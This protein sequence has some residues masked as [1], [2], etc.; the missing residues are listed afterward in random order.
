MCN[1]FYPSPPSLATYVAAAA[2]VVVVVIEIDLMSF[3]PQGDLTLSPA[4]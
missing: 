1:V 3:V 2:A 4:S